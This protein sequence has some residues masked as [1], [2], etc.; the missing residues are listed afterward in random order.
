[1]S[2]VLQCMYIRVLSRARFVLSLAESSSFEIY[3]ADMVFLKSVAACSFALLQALAASAGVPRTFSTPYFQGNS[4]TRRDLSAD[5]VASELGPLLSNGS[6]I[7]GPSN[8]S[9]TNATTRWIT[10]VQPDVE[11]VVQPAAESDISKIV[12]A[13]PPTSRHTYTDSRCRSSIATKIA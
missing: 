4:I 10:F 9:Y 3:L 7:F 12:F 6:L 11:V 13:S 8:P 2:A 5:I 1:M